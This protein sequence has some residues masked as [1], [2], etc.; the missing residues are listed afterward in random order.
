MTT[1]EQYRRSDKAKKYLAQLVV[2]FLEF[3]HTKD[4]KGQEVADYMD[5]LDGKWSWYCTTRNL[6][7]ESYKAFNNECEYLVKKIEQANEISKANEASKNHESE[8]G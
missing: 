2:S 3:L 5:K 6:T 1:S 4:I 7:K 8:Q